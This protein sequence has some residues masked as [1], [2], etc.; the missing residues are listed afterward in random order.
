[1]DLME[2]YFEQGELTEEQMRK[3]LHASMTKQ[4]LF[5]VFVSSATEN[6]G[7]SRVMDF[8]ANV[9]PAP[10]EIVP[11]PMDSGAVTFDASADPV[12][13]VYRTMAEQH[14]GEY[15]FLKVYDGT[16]K[17][18]LD[19]V[20]AQTGE[21]TRVSQLYAISGQSRESV[22]SVQA[23]DL[24]AAVKL[25]SAHTNN[26]LHL[27][28]SDV[29][30]GDIDFMAPRYRMAISAAKAGEEDKVGSGLNQIH[31]EDPS[32]VIEHDG[33]LNQITVGG[34]GELHL[35]I[36]SYL[37]SKRFGVEVEYSAPKIH[38]RETVTRRGDA[39]Y[40]HKKQTGGSG[41]FADITLYVEP[42]KGEYAP[43]SDIKV[44]QTH[45]ETTP[46]GSTVEFID[47]IVGGVIDMRRFFGAIQKGI[48]EALSQ[49]PV[50]GYPVGDVRVVVYDGGMHSVDSNEAAFKTAS[51]MAFKQAFLEA[52]PVLLEPIHTVEVT[53]PEPYM[54]DVLGD[55]NTRRARILGMTA[56]GGFQKIQ[57]HVPEAEMHRYSTSLRSLTQGRGLHA[58]EF[59]SYEPVPR[60]VQ[61]QLMAGA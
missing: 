18:G 1:E 9:L 40:R 27:K 34:Q 61:E 16:L 14:V 43:P 31:E 59:E 8:I 22:D 25:K 20:N 39:S 11:P 24:V 32:I 7:V 15:S 33:S 52:K 51:V 28:G 55:L 17:S 45:S 56:D 5:P 35:K 46:W 2:L 12:A 60:N 41:Q 36:V 30:V 19:L 6:I 58:A 13:F 10:N 42:M 3:G 23:G 4:Q 37:L 50:A 47:A 44:R 26:T 48:M 57:A 53:M 21:T 38:Y 54:G 49:G 29:V